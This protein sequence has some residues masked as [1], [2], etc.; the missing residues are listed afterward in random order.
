MLRISIMF[1][2]SDRWWI[3]FSGPRVTGEE[4]G[5]PEYPGPANIICMFHS[6]TVACVQPDYH[7]R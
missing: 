1:R 7:I 6:I 5:P 3:T 4:G 2:I